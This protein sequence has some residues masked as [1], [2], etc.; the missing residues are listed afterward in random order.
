[1][2]LLTAATETC[3]ARAMA[4]LD[5]PSAISA[6]TSRSRGVS[7]LSG[8]CRRRSNCPTTSGSSTV[9][10]PATRTTVSAN[11]VTAAT[12]SFSR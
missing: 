8:S 9:P 1:M 5:R 12:R 7:R 2:C 10:P 11:S 4:A 3:R 6:S